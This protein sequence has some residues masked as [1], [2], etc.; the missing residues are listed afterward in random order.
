MNIAMKKVIAVLAAFFLFISFAFSQTHLKPG[1]N[2]KEYLSL[3]DVFALQNDSMPNQ[4]K[5]STLKDYQ[6]IYQSPEGP[7]KN[8][9]DIWLQPDNVGIICIRGT[10]PNPVSWLE[11]FY[12]A[13]IPANCSL[14]I[15]DTTTFNYKLA[16]DSCA[17]VHVGWTLGLAYMAPLVVQQVNELYAKGVKEFFIFGHSQG[18]ALAFLMRSYLQYSN[19]VPKDIFFKTYGSAAPKPGDVKYVYDLDFITRGGWCLRVVNSEDW[20]PETP[21]TA[22]T[23]DDMNE[24]NP[25]GNISSMLGNQKWYVRWYINGMFRKLKKGGNSAME[26]YQKFLGKKLYP[27]IKKVLP[28][29]KQPVY[30]NTSNYM[31]AGTPIILMADSAYKQQFQFTG[32]NIFVHHLLAPYRY[33]VNAIYGKQ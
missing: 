22:Q 29:F 26:R 19:A 33:L 2:T 5:Y 28:Q 7:L 24:A 6:H 17:S 9:V 23:L 18:G 32:K 11:N 21:F 10:I 16:E 12:S 15:N 3:M 31:T 20:V 14:Q 13:M 8:R 25:F 30:A 4:A 1:F 27:Q